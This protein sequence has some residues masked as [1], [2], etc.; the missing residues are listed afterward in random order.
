MEKK[1][2]IARG[3]ITILALLGML[4]AMLPLRNVRPLPNMQQYQDVHQLITK[5]KHTEVFLLTNFYFSQKD[6]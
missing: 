3:I 5:Q 1:I 4:A 6:A 2:T